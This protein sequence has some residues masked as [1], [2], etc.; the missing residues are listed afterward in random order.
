M[1]LR[2]GAAKVSIN[3]PE[4]M[5]PYPSYFAGVPYGGIYSDCNVRAIAIDN[6]KD[7][8]LIVGF[9]LGGVPDAERMKTMLESDCGIPQ[10]N[11]RLSATHNH[12]GCDI[13]FSPD[14]TEQSMAEKYR[15]FARNQAVKAANEA[16]GRMRPAKYGYGK[17]ISY[18]NI[19][20]D[21]ECEDG[22]FTQG[23]EPKAYCDH[24][25]YLLKFVDE[26]NQMVA[27][28]ADFGMHATLGYFEFD[29]DGQAKMSG[30]IPGMAEE[31]V[32]ARY[33]NGAVLLWTS[34]AAGDQNPCMYTMRDYEQDGFPTMARML[35]GMQFQLITLLGRQHG[36]DICKGLNCINTYSSNMPMHFAEA[37]IQLPA[38]KMPGDYDPQ[39][40]NEWANHVR[41]LPRGMA[42]MPEVLPDDSHTVPLHME[43][44][45]FGDVAIVGVAAEIYSLIGRKIREISPYRKTL[46][47]TH[48]ANSAGYII[49]ATSTSHY[50]FEQ[51]GPVRAGACD[52]LIPEGVVGLFDQILK[53][54]L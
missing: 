48:I 18:V 1:S 6:G 10:A 7:R 46:V 9:D 8:A 28:V 32:E 17:G 36:V 37:E 16:I 31:Y 42:R 12:T 14:P 35:P 13:V 11:I 22:T 23:P 49:D 43:L 40:L 45:I 19:N 21:M 38:Q 2:V 24:T 50:C 51:Y 30:N 4:E 44:A 5:N 26:Q 41:R 29:K 20:R 52:E 33:G 34:A 15:E 47:V 54:Q 39:I 3:L 27:A 53:Q 25:V